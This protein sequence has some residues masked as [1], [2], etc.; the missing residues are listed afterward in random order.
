VAVLAAALGLALTAL[1][2]P[3]VA[4]AGWWSAAPGPA[5]SVS[6]M[7]SDSGPETLAI[8]QGV[9]GW[10]D[11]ARG[12]FRPVGRGS[13]AEFV[14]AHGGSGLVL[15]RDGR[16]LA[17]QSGGPTRALQTLPG[18][19]RGLGIAPGRPAMV[20]AATSAGIFWGTLGSPLSHRI[21]AGRGA[22][23]IE[24]TAPVAAGQPFWV[25]AANGNLLRL[26]RDGELLLSSQGAP[27][28]GTH[29]VLVELGD[30]VVLAGGRSG[31]IWGLYQGGWQPVFQL[32]PYGGIGGVPDLTAMISDGP[33]AAY[34]ATAGFGTLLTPDGGYTWYRAAPAA[35]DV[36]ALATIG[37]VFAS[38]PSGLVVAATPQGLFLHHL[39]ALP[40]PPTYQGASLKGQILGTAGVTVGA[41]ALAILGLWWLRRRARRG[42]SV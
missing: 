26:G 14:A 15:Y 20:V 28:L 41:A 6:Q 23:P 11:P 37:P 5:R 42:L 13:G 35:A 16:L 1:S 2:A 24:L 22:D 21:V 33:T 31:L 19:P 34:L 18:K 30:G 8:S 25:V 12:S 29:P 7:A 10:L 39:Q 9:A 17:T 4:A 40:A 27:H 32:L 3:P 36:Q 38:R